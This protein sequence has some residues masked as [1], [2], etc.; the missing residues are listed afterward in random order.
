MRRCTRPWPADLVRFASVS[1]THAA[2]VLAALPQRLSIN[3][4][5]EVD[6]LARS[7]AKRWTDGRQ[8]SGAGGLVDFVRGARAS[9]QGRSVIALSAT[10]GRDGRSRIVP[11]LRA[12]PVSLARADVD[13]VITDHGRAALLHLGV[14]ARE[15]ALIAIAAPEHRAGLQEAWHTLRR[16]L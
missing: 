15:Q 7:T 2:A 16:S 14:D 4:A 3:G 5:L 10:A 12:G 13:E 8:R 6:L 1:H 9:K 11:L